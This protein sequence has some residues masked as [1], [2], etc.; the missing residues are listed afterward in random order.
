MNIIPKLSQIF[1]RIKYKPT[2]GKIL[3][4]RH[5]RH[6][7]PSIRMPAAYFIYYSASSLKPLREFDVSTELFYPSLEEYLKGIN[8]ISVSGSPLVNK[9]QILLRSNPSSD[10]L[11]RSVYFAL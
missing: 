9:P 10:C 2:P 3:H 4:T 11:P 5:I 7:M 6:Q 8:H 1:H